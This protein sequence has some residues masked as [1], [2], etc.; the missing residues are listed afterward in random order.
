MQA[1]KSYIHMCTCIIIM[2]ST[3]T[4]KGYKNSNGV[5]HLFNFRVS[6]IIHQTTRGFSPHIKVL[7]V[8]ITESVVI[9][10]I[11]LLHFYFFSKEEYTPLVK[12][13]YTIYL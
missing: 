1:Y 5:D 12:M 7:Y 10:Q 9:D 13:T 4:T 11:Y 8:A 6:Y 3:I 2:E